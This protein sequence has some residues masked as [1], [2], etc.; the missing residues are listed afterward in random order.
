MCLKIISECYW[1]IMFDTFCLYAHKITKAIYKHHISPSIIMVWKSMVSCIPYYMYMYQVNEFESKLKIVHCFFQ[2]TSL[3]L[4]FLTEQITITRKILMRIMSVF[5][6]NHLVLS[7]SVKFLRTT[8]K[9][10]FVHCITII[11]LFCVL[12]RA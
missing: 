4:W 1:C 6:N 3:I 2:W 7:I 5:Y 11:C 12:L 8:S 10:L 9:C